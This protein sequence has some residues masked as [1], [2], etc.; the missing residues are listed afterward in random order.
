MA[1][2]RKRIALSASTGQS[3]CHLASPCDLS[4]SKE[5]LRPIAWHDAEFRYDTGDPVRFEF[6]AEGE[7]GQSY[8]F[9]SSEC[10]ILPDQLPILVVFDSNA[11]GD[12]GASEI[13][14]I[15]LRQRAA[16]EPVVT[17]R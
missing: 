7:G 2:E 12:N 9:E 3:A 10:G 6:T 16:S 8:T 17:V 11:A 1:L 14:W 15:Y 5:S 13:D 4:V